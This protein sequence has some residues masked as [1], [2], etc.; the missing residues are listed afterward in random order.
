MKFCCIQR[1]K[2]AKHFSFSVLWEKAELIGSSLANVWKCAALFNS[3]G[4]R[5]I[6]RGVAAITPVRKMTCKSGHLISVLVIPSI[7]QRQ[8]SSGP[9]SLL[10][11]FLSSH[12]HLQ[13]LY[14]L[15]SHSHYS[16][17]FLS[18]SRGR[19]GGRSLSSFSPAALCEKISLLRHKPMDSLK[20]LC[21]ALQRPPYEYLLQVWVS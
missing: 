5:S 2:R 16:F 9:S 20:L 14:N 7:P 8:S 10:T 3:H 21:G 1:F 15:L 17:S 11:T 19:K 18:P 4:E 13:H 12:L 6:F